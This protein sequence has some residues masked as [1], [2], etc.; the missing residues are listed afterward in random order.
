MAFIDESGDAG[1][2]GSKSSR[3]IIASVIIA[4]SSEDAL[5]RAKIIEHKRSLG[6]KDRDEFKFSRTRKEVIKEL[7]RTLAPYNYKIYCVV[8]NKNKLRKDQPSE[9]RYTLY[10]YVLAEL[11][12]LLPSGDI[13]ICIDGDAGKKYRK[14]T[15][16]FLRKQLGRALRI[17]N[18][19]FADSRSVEGLQL[20]DIVAGSI[21]RSYSNH[22]DKNA[23][24][25]LISDKIVEI[26]EL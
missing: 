14:S 16:T 10:N 13:R 21:N 19:K 8:Q 1:L 5:I 12:K 23:Y 6:W 18:L 7:L 25:G 15:I 24:I 9:T 2:T 20:A 17:T 22:I 26:K 11:L 4:N 3:L